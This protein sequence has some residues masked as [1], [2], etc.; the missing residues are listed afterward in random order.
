MTANRQEVDL[1]AWKSCRALC[2]A[3]VSWYR[4]YGKHPGRIVRDSHGVEYVIGDW[5]WNRARRPS[6]YIEGA[7]ARALS[8]EAQ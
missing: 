6:E 2:A 7:M 8:E 4:R 1:D 3:E 5:S